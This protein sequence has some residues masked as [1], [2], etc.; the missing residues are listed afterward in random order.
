MNT[1]LANVFNYAVTGLLAQGESAGSS[2]NK[3]QLG[4]VVA[5]GDVLGGGVVGD[6]AAAHDGMDPGLGITHRDRDLEHQALLG[7]GGDVVVH[8]DARA[9]SGP[10]DTHH[11][12]GARIVFKREHRARDQCDAVVAVAGAYVAIGR[13]ARGR[14]NGD[15]VHAVGL[16]GVVE[17]DGPPGVVKVD[18]VPAVG[19]AVVELQCPVGHHREHQWVKG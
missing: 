12:S 11:V 5:E 16:T 18:A 4:F 8:Y 17:D 14:E 7:V 10:L 13:H 9:G 6:G 1:I 19:A 15:A 3:V 2:V